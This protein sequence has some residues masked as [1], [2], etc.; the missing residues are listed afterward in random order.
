MLIQTCSGLVGQVLRYSLSFVDCIVIME[1]EHTIT[2][3]FNRM[4]GTER[5]KFDNFD[6]AIIFAKAAFDKPK[7]KS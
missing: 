4:D 5:A 6:D 7:K 1:K 3:T 2:I